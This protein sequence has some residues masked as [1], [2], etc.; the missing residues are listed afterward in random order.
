M[1]GKSSCRKFNFFI[2]KIY[3]GIFVGVFTFLQKVGVVHVFSVFINCVNL[4]EKLLKST[5]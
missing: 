1:C 3:I 5:N 2:K 4:L